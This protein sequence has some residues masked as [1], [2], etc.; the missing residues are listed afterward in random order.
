MEPSSGR[1]GDARRDAR[2]VSGL[3]LHEGLRVE[4]LVGFFVVA[5]LDE[6]DGVG[7]DRVELEPDRA[8]PLRPERLDG[9]DNLGCPLVVLGEDLGAF[10][11]RGHVVV[12]E[13]LEDPELAAVR[14]QAPG[15]QARG[16]YDAARS[17][18]LSLPLPD[19]PRGPAVPSRRGR[20]SEHP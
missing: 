1:S 13:D 5:A 20:G 12:P 14:R 11:Q 6:P 8:G 16:A 17:A 9:V 7:D 4:E 10:R 15:A 19:H 2:Q 18:H 3:E